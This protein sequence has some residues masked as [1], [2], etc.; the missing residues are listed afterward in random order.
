MHRVPLFWRFHN[1]HHVDPDVDV[2]TATRFHVGEIA[3]SA[4]VR[5]LQIGIIGISW[6]AYLL[7]EIV[8]QAAA[9]FHHS[10]VRLPLSMEKGVN[11]V[12]VTPRMHGIHHS[13]FRNETNSN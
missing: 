7:Y 2:T 11:L 3:A 6:P 4:G 8:F 13:Q 12:F 9:L 1:V 10:N 5:A